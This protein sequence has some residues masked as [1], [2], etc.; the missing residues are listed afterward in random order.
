M[1]VPLRDDHLLLLR[2]ADSFDREALIRALEPTGFS[3]YIGSRAAIGEA[4]LKRLLVSKGVSYL[5]QLVPL[6]EAALPPGSPDERAPLLRV[7][8]DMIA[9]LEPTQSFIVVD[10]YLLPVS[11]VP[12]DYVAE[13]AT[14]L[15]PAASRVESLRLVT[16]RFDA[17][18]L[19]S[20]VAAL[21]DTCPACAVSHATSDRY[22]DRFWIAD[23]ARGLFV[24]TSPNGIG[25]RYALVDYLSEKDVTDIVDDLSAE[26]LLAP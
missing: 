6:R 12:P 19:G 23:R 20:L 13:L 18:L 7:L 15:E 5:W 14:L 25:R 26:R 11:A 10:R 22:H 21:A 3:A 8:A 9:N 2:G 16:G 4:E 24:G 1:E 17:M